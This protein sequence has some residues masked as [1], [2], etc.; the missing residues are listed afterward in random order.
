MSWLSYCITQHFFRISLFFTAE[1]IFLMDHKNTLATAICSIYTFTH[2]NAI[3]FCTY[4][5]EKHRLGSD[6]LGYGS[7]LH[8]LISLLS[9]TCLLRDIPAMMALFLVPKD[10]TL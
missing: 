2:S 5:G 9:H 3:S 4:A 10:N 7:A 1:R 8:I 6:I